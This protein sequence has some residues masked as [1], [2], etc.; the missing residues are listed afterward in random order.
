MKQLLSWSYVVIKMLFVTLT[1]CTSGKKLKERRKEKNGGKK[2]AVHFCFCPTFRDLK[3]LFSGAKNT[4]HLQIK[5]KWDHNLTNTSPFILMLL[6]ETCAFTSCAVVNRKQ[7]SSRSLGPE[8]KRIIS[9]LFCCCSCC[10]RP[11]GRAQW[12]AP[13]W[14]GLMFTKSSGAAWFSSQICEDYPL[15]SEP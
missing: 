7:Q 1:S 4:P 14:L 3:A 10:P 11:V 6:R 2:C 5:S 9:L 12:N 15:W 8:K 13:F